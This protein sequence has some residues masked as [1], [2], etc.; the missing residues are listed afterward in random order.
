MTA[1]ATS[2]N[3]DPDLTQADNY[4]NLTDDVGVPILS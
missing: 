4:S 2:C 1:E 3:S